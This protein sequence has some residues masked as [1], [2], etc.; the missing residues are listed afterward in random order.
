MQKQP[1]QRSRYTDGIVVRE[2]ASPA[3]RKLMLASSLAYLADD[4]AAVCIDQPDER[5]RLGELA[6]DIHDIAGC[7]TALAEDVG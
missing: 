6:S 2:R 1:R 5:A 7:V 3:E 4:L